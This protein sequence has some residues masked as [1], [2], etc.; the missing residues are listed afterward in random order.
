MPCIL[1]EHFFFTNFEELNKCNTPEF[2]EIAAEVTVRAL[3]EYVGITYK[4]EDAVAEYMRIIQEKCQFSNP[5][6]VWDVIEKYHPYPEALLM[7]WAYSYK[8]PG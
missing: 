7:Q 1:I 3:C 4:P 6:G 2:I 5:Q 8:T